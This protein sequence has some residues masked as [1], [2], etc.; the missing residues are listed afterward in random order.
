MK[1]AVIIINTTDNDLFG[2]TFG[3]CT[4]F[5]NNEK[6]MRGRTLARCESYL[7]LL[8]RE[9]YICCSE[10]FISQISSTKMFLMQENNITASLLIV[11]L[12][13]GIIP[14]SGS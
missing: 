5:Y 1:T 10:K 9:R 6:Y 13:R 3:Y 4:F 14:Q 7:T 8:S 2:N 12:G 11:F